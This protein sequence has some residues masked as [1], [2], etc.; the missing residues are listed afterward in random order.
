MH[1]TRLESLADGIFAIVMTLLVFELRVPDISTSGGDLW[2]ELLALI[3]SF[4]AYILSFLVLTTYWMGHHFIVS[5]YAK[6]MSRKLAFLN[7]PF[8]MFVCLVPF[9]SRMLGLYPGNQ[10]AVII[11]GI[12]VILIGISLYFILEYVIKSKEIKNPKLEARNARYGY[13]RV[14]LPICSATIAIF[15]SFYSTRISMYIFILTV[16]FNIIPGTLSTLDRS[17]SKVIKSV[18]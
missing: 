17:L 12:N 8:L 1:K 13:I 5:L 9:S 7:V 14:L 10:L 16:L 3:P 18:S 6:N 4:L 11:Y 2:Y 15:A